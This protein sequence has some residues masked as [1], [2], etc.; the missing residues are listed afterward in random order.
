MTSTNIQA[1]IEELEATLLK[2]DSE[3]LS[4][5]EGDL[6]YDTDDNE[7][8]VAR[9]VSGTLQFIPLLSA[10]GTMDNLDGGGFV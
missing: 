1:A 8:K 5:E 4:Y 6:W 2:Q 3:P 10:T 7:L 9:E